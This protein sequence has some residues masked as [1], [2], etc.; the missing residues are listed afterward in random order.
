MTVTQ[1]NIEFRP[2]TS[3]GE[4]NFRWLQ[5]KHSFSFGHYYDPQN[6]SYRSL[7]VIND[8]IIA[9]GGGFGEHPHENME[10][11]TWVLSGAIAHQ[12]S[13]SGGGA[14]GVIQPG[15]LQMMTA[16]S[17][18]RHSEMNPSNTEPV[19]LLQIWI[20]PAKQQLPPSY[21][22]KNFARDGRQGRWQILASS[23]ARGG[24]TRINQ[25]AV[26]SVSEISAGSSIDLFLSEKRHGYLHVAYGEISFGDL[27]LEAGDAVTITGPASLKL[28]AEQ[29]SQVL[30]FDLA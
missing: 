19:H 21:A 20:E 5:S 2:G 13:T 6:N 8:D 9:G 12:D 27:R 23:D 25:D 7:R 14:G 15:D 22:Q 1:S 4:T 10:I 16:G 24:S 17:G 26:F 28:D 3:R 29:D 18:I 11:L 30:F